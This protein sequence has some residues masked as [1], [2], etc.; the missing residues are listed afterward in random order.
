MRH[1]TRWSVLTS[2]V[3]SVVAIAALA[4]PSPAYA[5]G[6]STIT[7][8]TPTVDQVIQRDVATGTADVTVSG[9][10]D[11][12]GPLEASLDGADWTSLTV[13]GTTFSGVVE[14]QPVGRSTLVVRSTTT[15]SVSASVARVG[16]GDV[17]G[18]MGDSNAV[19]SSYVREVYTGAPGQVT[20]FT[21]ARIWRPLLGDQVDLADEDSPFQNCKWILFY[22]LHHALYDA[23]ETGSVWPLVATRLSTA[24][25][26]IPIGLVVM[27]RGGG[28]L[29]CPP[30]KM[31]QTCWQKPTGPWVNDPYWS[32]SA[33]VLV[34]LG[35]MGPP[36]SLR[37]VLWFEGVNDTG[38]ATHPLGRSVY[39][40]WVNR[41]AANL[42]ADYGPVDL[43]LSATGDCDP[44]LTPDCAGRDS[45]LDNVRG[46]VADAWAATPGVVRGP[47][48]YD[49]DKSSGTDPDGRHYRS[50]AAMVS[51]AERIADSL[52][53]AY[54]GGPSQVGPKLVSASGTDTSVRLTFD[55]A[56]LTPGAQVGGIRVERDGV[57]IPFQSAIAA[58][59]H[60]VDVALTGS[61]GTLTASVAA[62]RT[63]REPGIV[64]GANGLPAE[65]VLRTAVQRTGPDLTAP[66]GTVTINAGAAQT[67][68]SAVTLTIQATDDR[69]TGA[70]LEMQVSNAANLSDATWQPFAA[71][72]P[73]SLV[74]GT[75]AR[76]VYVR[77]RDPAGNVSATA[78][79]SITV[80]TAPAGPV[81][82]V[83]GQ[84]TLAGGAFAANI[85]P[86]DVFG[87]RGT[88]YIGGVAYTQRNDVTRCGDS[89]V[90]GTAFAPFKP[91]QAWKAELSAGTV[92]VNGV[93][94]AITSGTLSIL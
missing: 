30:D 68:S 73:W 90:Q 85:R 33:D 60:E 6:P 11:V 37:A 84:L 46:A 12:A 92:T 36:G 41:F 83:G 67:S 64:R 59:D 48:L 28:G 2:V 79:R 27:G 93:T 43:V 7:I 55:A 52:T 47:V 89:C 31:S 17:F 25:P 29:N 44:A 82:Y 81:R 94:K 80:A 88:V 13:T 65:V 24:A 18:V 91:N 1:G 53:V 66:T 78:S 19:G 56:S 42:R 15:P 39:L 16:V 9:I 51:A 8:K 10:V 49:I 14:D 22:C 75:G 5:V 38:A 45:G 50:H 63:G 34:R 3:V 32:L 23:G 74:A 62:G 70:A 86:A 77:F 21:N 76:A 54:Y 87:L 71:S 57:A 4:L 40:A 35:A 61:G 26:G 20:M 72:L 58:S 69:A